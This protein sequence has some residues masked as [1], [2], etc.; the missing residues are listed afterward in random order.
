[1]SQLGQNEP[2]QQS[3]RGSAKDG[4]DATKMGRPQMASAVAQ[5]R[6]SPM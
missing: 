5:R 1:M 3:S 2:L 4:A 6:E